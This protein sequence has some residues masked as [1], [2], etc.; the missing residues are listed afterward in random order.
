M[1]ND[2]LSRLIAGVDKAQAMRVA[3][4]YRTKYDTD[5]ANDIKNRTGSDF[6]KVLLTWISAPDPTGGLEKALMA[7]APGSSDVKIQAARN[8][9]VSTESAGC[10]IMVM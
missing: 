4:R 6:Q 8:V 5:L 9:M 2:T 1:D 7:D 10:F 3:E